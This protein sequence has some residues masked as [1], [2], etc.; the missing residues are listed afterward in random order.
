MPFVDILGTVP[1]ICLFGCKIQKN[2]ANR[3]QKYR[4]EFRRRNR[5]LRSKWWC[6]GDLEQVKAM[7]L[8]HSALPDDTRTV[9]NTVQAEL[10]NMD[11]KSISARSLPDPHAISK[12]SHI[13]GPKVLQNAWVRDVGKILFL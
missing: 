7:I 1:Y 6:F 11:L 8:T 2:P 5:T 12:S 13:L 4:G 10:T 9:V 3:R